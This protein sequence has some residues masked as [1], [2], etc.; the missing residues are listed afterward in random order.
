MEMSS[1]QSR[2]VLLSVGVVSTCESRLWGVEVIKMVSEEHVELGDSTVGG[3][4]S[5]CL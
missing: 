3:D 2:V 1:V 5:G 4:G